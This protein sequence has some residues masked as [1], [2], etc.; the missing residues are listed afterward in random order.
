MATETNGSSFFRWVRILTI[1]RNP[2]FTLIRI[3]V[4][5]VL[6]VLVRNYAL[7][8]IRVVGPSML[9]TYEENGV[10]FVNRLAYLRSEPK[11]GDVVAIRYAGEHRLLMKRVIGLPGE[12]IEFRNGKVFI[13]GERLEEPYMTANY[14]SRW[15]LEPKEIQPGHYYV[16][17]DNRT[18]PEGA[19]VHGRAE[20]SRIVGKILLC[21]N[22]FASSPSPR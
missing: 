14:P 11:R 9:P 18:M 7:L 15:T 2:Q 19:H 8:P 20:R 1:G 13:N 17:G 12:V 10:N 5:V 22:W 3:V 21:K 4:L 16:V 6:V